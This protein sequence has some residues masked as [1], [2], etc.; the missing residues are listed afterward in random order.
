MF[1]VRLI[2]VVSETGSEET[3]LGNLGELYQDILMR[4]VNVPTNRADLADDEVD[5]EE[6]NPLCGDRVKM[7]ITE[8][9]GGVGCVRFDGE[10]CAICMASASI[11]AAAAAGLAPDVG[12]A[13]CERMTRVCRGEEDLGPEDS[14]ELGAVAGVR[15]FPMRVKCAVLPWRALHQAI[16]HKFVSSAS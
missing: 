9:H 13:L 1:W 16:I 6:F 10:G 14:D 12:I 2:F 11:A 4:H 3:N 15:S 8:E 5:A 7:S